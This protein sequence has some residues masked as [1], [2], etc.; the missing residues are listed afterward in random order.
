MMITNFLGFVLIALIIWWFWLYKP[1]KTT[2]D[3]SEVIIEVN[4]G[5]YSPASIQVP[6]RQPITLKFIR[7]DQSPCSEALLIPTLDVSEQ[8]K[9]GEVTQINLTNL[10]PGEYAF[11]CQMQMY[12]GVIKVI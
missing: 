11:H 10:M 6:A 5:V 12:C 8:L 9:L 1:N 3:T 7:K 4:D 2:V